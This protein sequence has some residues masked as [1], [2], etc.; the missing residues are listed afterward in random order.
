M[1]AQHFL[2]L[3]GPLS[4]NIYGTVLIKT[5]PDEYFSKMYYLKC[6]KSWNIFVQY[7]YSFNTIIKA[8][9]NTYTGTV[10]LFKSDFVSNYNSVRNVLLDQNR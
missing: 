4:K 9:Y 2:V 8:A 10:R 6:R 3:L 1:R 7:R 5:F